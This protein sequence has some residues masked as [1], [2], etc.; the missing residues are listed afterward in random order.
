MLA[1][2]TGEGRG[3]GWKR[4]GH[5]EGWREAGGAGSVV[6][7]GGT[8]GARGRGMDYITSFRNVTVAVAADDELHAARR[9]IMSGAL[10]QVELERGSKHEVLVAPIDGPY[11]ARTVEQWEAHVAAHG[12]A[13]AVS[14]DGR[15][16]R[17][18]ITA[19]WR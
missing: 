12:R 14:V 2:L 15:Q 10:E 1:I 6:A 16:D 8:G 13:V 11:E 7:T 3:V 17:G 4:G 9:R 19:T 18:S 5:R